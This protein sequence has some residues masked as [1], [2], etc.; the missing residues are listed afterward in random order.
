MR[1]FIDNRNPEPGKFK[2]KVLEDSVF[3]EPTALFID[4]KSTGCASFIMEEATHTLGSLYKNTNPIHEGSTPQD[5]PLPKIPPP[6]PS[7]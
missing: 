3:R 6:L 7:P 5:Q 4:G 1:W 2:I